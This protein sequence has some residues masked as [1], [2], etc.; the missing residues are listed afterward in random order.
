MV[1]KSSLEDVLLLNVKEGINHSEMADI[2]NAISDQIREGHV[3]V[4]ISLAEVESINYFSLGVLVERLTRLRSCGGDL[5]FVGMNNY[6]KNA[7]T[8]IGIAGAIE[9]F[10]SVGEAKMSFS[11]C[12]VLD[13][14]DCC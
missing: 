11:K 2:R 9:N 1:E 13:R 6:L 12:H 7:F 14:K 3:K 8:L 4:I 10:E 5:K